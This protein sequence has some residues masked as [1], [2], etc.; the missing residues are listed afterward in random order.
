MLAAGAQGAFA[1]E[2]RT[3]SISAVRVEWRAVL[4]QLRAEIGTQP[5]IASRFTFSGQRRVPA[6]DPRSMPALVQLNAITSP[7]FA[8]IGR[9]PVPVLLPFDTS[10]Y[11]EARATGAPDTL[12][13]SRF[14]ADFRPVDLFHAGPAGYDAQFSLAPGAGDGL[15]S[16]TFA[17]PVEV[18]IT[19]SIL[20]YD[21]ADPLGNKGEPVKALAAQFPDMRRF[22]R[23]GYV[24]YAFTRFGVP[25][26][27][28][29]QCLDSTP[30]SRRLGCREAYPIAERFLKALRIAGGQPSRPRFDISSDIAERP[31][32]ISPDFTYRPSGDI[33]AH[34]GTRKRGGHADDAAYSQIRFPLEKAPAFVRSQSFGKRKAQERGGLYPWRDNFCEARSFQVGQCAAGF[35]HQGQDIRPAPCPQNSEDDDSCHP[36]KQAVVAVRDGVVIRSLRQQ[37][38]TLQINTSNEHIRFRY[39]HMNPSAMDADG[40]LNGR[41]VTEG[42]KIGVV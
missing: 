2:F 33:I 23:E 12:S 22:I 11:L 26:V 6:W 7:I 38:A 15:P 5:S 19:G 14:Q 42:E 35:G 16:R 39:M 20:I 27:V 40:I 4:D 41:R 28:S 9:S 36:G 29:I 10:A 13:V 21:L 18:Q 31:T 34:S 8:G 3:P 37:A 30:R 1:G 24:R 17:R 32:S 25:Y